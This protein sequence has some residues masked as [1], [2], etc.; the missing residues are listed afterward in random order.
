MS[1]PGDP[2]SGEF[3]DL[4][5]IS[6]SGNM[7]MLPVSHKLTEI[8]QFFQYHDTQLICD[9]PGAT[10]TATK[11]SGGKLEYVVLQRSAMR[12]TLVYFLVF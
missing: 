1:L 9:D 3:R 2:G 7:K 11:I 4:S 6:R 12:F 5:I 8:T 10:A